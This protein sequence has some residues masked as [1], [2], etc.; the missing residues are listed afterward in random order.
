MLPVAS[1][2]ATYTPLGMGAAEDEVWA[3]NCMATPPAAGSAA[4]RGC[5][6]GKGNTKTLNTSV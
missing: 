6:A 2:V 3:M 4:P 5:T 1:G